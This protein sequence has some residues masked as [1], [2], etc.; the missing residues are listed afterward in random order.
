[1]DTVPDFTLRIPNRCRAHGFV[2]LTREAND[3]LASY[4]GDDVTLNPSLCSAKL[5]DRPFFF[6]PA[7]GLG[8][9]RSPIET[10]MRN[11]MSTHKNMPAISL[12]IQSNIIRESARNLIAWPEMWQPEAEHFAGSR[13]IMH[14]R[15]RAIFHGRRHRPSGRTDIRRAPHCAG[16]PGITGDYQAT[17]EYVEEFRAALN[18][19]IRMK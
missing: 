4:R 16:A 9:M 14:P 3:H 1:V 2:Q 11:G 12:C 17:R 7:R 13:R 19:R 8:F 15:S 10:Q 18:T 5:R 6:Q